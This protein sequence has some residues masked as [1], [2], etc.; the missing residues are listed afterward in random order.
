MPV[1]QYRY[2]QAQSYTLGRKLAIDAIILHSSDGHEEGD[3]ATLTGTDPAVSSHWYVTKDGRYWHFVQ[4]SDTAYHAGVVD[5][6]L[7]SNAATI[8]IEQE[9][10]DG[11]EEWPDAL[12]RAT[13]NL[14]AFLRQRHGPHLSVLSH[15]SVARP[16]GRKVDPKDYPW[17]D[18][19]TYTVHAMQT[20][21]TAEEI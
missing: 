7:H 12:V 8:G 3:V 18:L 14:I 19:H 4:D 21:W 16:V 6:V 9:H 5:D 1:I 11:A 13:A 10:I 15:A 20:V 2:K 17:G